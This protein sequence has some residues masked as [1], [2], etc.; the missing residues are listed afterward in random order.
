VCIEGLT[1]KVSLN[2]KI[3]TIIRIENERYIVEITGSDQVSLKPEHLVALPM[4]PPSAHSK[5]RKHIIAPELPLI[6][7]RSILDCAPNPPA[8]P[9]SIHDAGATPRKA[10]KFAATLLDMGFKLA[11]IQV[12]PL[13]GLIHVEALDKMLE[14]A[15]QTSTSHRLVRPTA[16]A[17]HEPLRPHTRTNLLSRPPALTVGE[18]VLARWPQNG[19]KYAGRF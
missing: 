6:P 11:D 17:V 14:L 15:Q 8:A 3:G 2:G 5:K 9:A 18:P 4:Q 1:K 7:K 13:D 12:L 10:H 19:G 16:L